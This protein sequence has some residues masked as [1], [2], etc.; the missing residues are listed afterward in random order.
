MSLPVVTTPLLPTATSDA[1]TARHMPLL[2][3]DVAD[4]APLVAMG[5]SVIDAAGPSP[6]SKFVVT[7]P[8]AGQVIEYA[9]W[10]DWD[11][12]HLYDLEHV[13]V[14]LDANGA[15]VRV[16]GTMHGMRVCADAGTGLPEM[17][18]DRPVLYLEPG[19]HAVWPAPRAMEAIAG[20]MIR[21]ACG[22]EAGLGGVHTG[23]SF[24]ESGKIR[25][26]SMDDRLARLALRRAGFAPRF[27]FA[28]A[29]DVPMVSW[30]VLADWIPSHVTA[31]MAEL[32]NQVPHLAAVFLDC[33]DTLID[34]AT[35]VKRA[36]TEVVLEANEIPHAMQAVRD[37]HSAGYRLALVADGPCETF[38][39]LLKPR[40][41]WDLM[42]GLAISGAVGVL[43]PA[44]EMF[45]TAMAALDLPN[46]ARNR[47]IMV[48]NNLSRDIRGAND[49]GL[50]SIFVGWSTRRS[51]RPENPSE[52]PD[53]TIR[54]LDQLVPTIEAMELELVS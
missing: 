13:W 20:G 16:E 35:E 45:T 48:G 25:P 44:P 14:H 1:L 36:G 38:E 33:G 43:K 23:N 31:V 19:K 32:P 53:R 39:N 7:P 51:Q 24:V 29:P 11:I 47:V 8:M 10:F 2:M 34:E 26:N 12:Q 46:S 21:A 5:V 40:G 50:R 52:V 9:L 6:S 17:Q 37:L 30:P 18:G 22:Q 49:F 4:P 27:R 42:E 15:V 28:P 54:T 41:I 3:Q